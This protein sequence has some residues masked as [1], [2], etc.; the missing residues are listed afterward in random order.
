M[1]KATEHEKFSNFI[2]I[3]HSH[4]QLMLGELVSIS[5]GKILYV[6]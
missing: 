4:T 1:A 5:L 3:I 2:I 6:I